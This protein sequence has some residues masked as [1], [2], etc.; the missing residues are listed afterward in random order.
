MIQI[1]TNSKLVKTDNI[2]K[3]LYT[4]LQA[5]AVTKRGNSTSAT[6]TCERSKNEIQNST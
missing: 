5:S 1:M 2:L 3:S 6:G 4:Y